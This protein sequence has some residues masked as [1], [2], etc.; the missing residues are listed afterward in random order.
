MGSCCLTPKKDQINF[1]CKTVA[2]ETDKKE[3]EDEPDSPDEFVINQEGKKC[4]IM[5]KRCSK[6]YRNKME[7]ANRKL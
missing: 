3:Y 7:A 5:K 4:K 2:N 1:A 6:Y